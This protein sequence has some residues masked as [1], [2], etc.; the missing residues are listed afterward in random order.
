[1][2]LRGLVFSLFLI[3]H[4]TVYTEYEGRSSTPQKLL[5]L[6]VNNLRNLPVLKCFTF[7][8]SRH[9]FKLN[10]NLYYFGGLTSIVAYLLHPREDRFIEEN[11]NNLHS[12]PKGVAVN[13]MCLLQQK[14][15]L[16]FKDGATRHISRVA[17]S[18]VQSCQMCS[19][20]R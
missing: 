5:K 17:Q 20:W 4:V 19:Y 16:L 8:N 9:V 2:F 3:P 7:S 13:T 11:N 1:M 10:V 15:T 18:P 6:I 14:K 12:A